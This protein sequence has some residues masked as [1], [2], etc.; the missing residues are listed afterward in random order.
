[1]CFYCSEETR[2]LVDVLGPCCHPRPHSYPL[3]ILLPNV[4]VL[5][6]TVDRL[7]R[8]LLN[9]LLLEP[10]LMSMGYAATRAH[11]DQEFNKH[12]CSGLNKY[13]LEHS[14]FQCLAIGTGTIRRYGLVEIDVI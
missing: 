12:D 3:S 7:F 4:C 8:C 1:M 6:P 9:V 5:R 13:G 14:L 10:L 2:D 11:T